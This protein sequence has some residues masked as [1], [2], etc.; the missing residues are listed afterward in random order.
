MGSQSSPQ[1]PPQSSQSSP[2]GEQLQR[3]NGSG[4]VTL[5]TPWTIACQA[6]LPMGFSRQE[7]WSGLL[8][9]SPGDL[10]DPGIE[11][12]SPALQAESQ[13]SES[14]GTA[15]HY[16]YIYT[17]THTCIIYLYMMYMHVCKM[18]MKKQDLN[19]F[20]VHQKH[21]IVN[22]PYFNKIN[23]NNTKPTFEYDLMFPFETMNSL[24]SIQ[25]YLVQHPLLC[26]L[27]HTLVC[28]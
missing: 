22:E 28:F 6:P 11:P 24:Y 23:L 3:R 26:L 9:P 2:T 27:K 20:A 15:N 5:V 8:F 18:L 13:P 17:H 19:H 1:S 7:Y 12:R 14:P 21:N 4:L 10:S 25:L 16:I